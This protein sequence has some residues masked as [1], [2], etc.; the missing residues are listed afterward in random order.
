MMAT[1]GGLT[2]DDFNRMWRLIV[3]AALAHPAT[4]KKEG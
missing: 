4:D 2:V 3:P 1:D